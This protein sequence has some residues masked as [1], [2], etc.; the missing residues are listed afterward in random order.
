MQLITFVAITIVEELVVGI[1]ERLVHLPTL[2]AEIAAQNVGQAH[3][4]QLRQRLGRLDLPHPL[5]HRTLPTTLGENVR[6]AFAQIGF[7]P[8][9]TARLQGHT[10]RQKSAQLRK[11]HLFDKTEIARIGVFLVAQCITGARH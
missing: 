10:T 6:L 2:T 8:Q 9:F 5:Q 1:V 7:Q 4:G 11:T 3:P